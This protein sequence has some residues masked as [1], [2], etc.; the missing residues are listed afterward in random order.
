[1]NEKIKSIDA[2]YIINILLSYFDYALVA[3]RICPHTSSLIPC[4]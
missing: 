1:M 4:K 2:L 3:L